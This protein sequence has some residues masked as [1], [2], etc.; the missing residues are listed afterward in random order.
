MKLVQKFKELVR[1]IKR[2]VGYEKVAVVKVKKH[3]DYYNHTNAEIK[4]Q[5]EWR[6]YYEVDIKNLFWN[7]KNYTKF[8]LRGSYEKDM[9][10]KPHYK[11]VYSFKKF[12]SKKDDFAIIRRSMV[13]ISKRPID[14]HKL[15][16]GYIDRSI[17]NKKDKGN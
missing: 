5:S 1:F 3:G 4:V 7:V 14:V 16:I 17:Y 6:R 12:V 9:H 11:Y 2:A 10:G 8:L 15:K 13:E